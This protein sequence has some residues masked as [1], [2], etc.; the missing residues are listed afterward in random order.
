MV[1]AD[2]AVDAFTAEQV[3]GIDGQVDR[4]FRAHDRGDRPQLRAA[5]DANLDWNANSAF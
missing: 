1:L 3:T 2:L 4:F 5:V